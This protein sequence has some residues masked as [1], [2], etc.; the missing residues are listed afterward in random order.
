MGAYIIAEAGVNHNGSLDMALD[1]VNAAAYAGADAVKFQTFKA[2]KLVQRDASKA[3]YQKK[4]TCSNESQFKMLRRLELSEDDH[5]KIQSACVKRGINF[6]S[7]PFD[8]DSLLFLA[9]NLRLKKIK[10]GSGEI[11]NAPLLLKAAKENLSVILSTG[12]SSLGEVEM[13]LG[14]LAFGYMS[15]ENPSRESLIAAY[16]DKRARAILREKVTLL[17][18]TSEYPAPLEDVNLN[19]MET[20][21]RAFGLPVGYSDH[22]SGI[23]IPLAAV[24]LGATVV[25]KHFTL[26]KNLSG[27]DHR[28]SVEPAELAS[29]I[30]AIRSVELALGNGIKSITPSEKA[31]RQAV[32]KHLVFSQDLE[33][34]TVLE[35]KHLTALRPERGVSPMDLW[36]VLGQTIRKN[37]KAGESF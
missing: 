17:H 15:L 19:S 14:C 21:R 34:G 26:D 12:M 7:S 11:T 1:L 8:E 29:M 4:T 28:A 22:T 10:L 27:P 31:N 13:A 32:R 5:R 24:A 2:K 36:N 6:L 23:W 30:K 18:C 20:M 35:E 33:A 25:E 37:I 9:H 16:S 3:E